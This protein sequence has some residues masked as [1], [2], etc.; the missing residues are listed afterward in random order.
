[1]IKRAKEATK[2]FPRY[3]LPRA[4][5]LVTEPWTIENGL[6]TPTLK[7]KR[8]PLRNKFADE[9]QQMYKA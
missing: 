9:I 4:V 2:D 5:T 3:A 8:G 6:L 7:L 1:V